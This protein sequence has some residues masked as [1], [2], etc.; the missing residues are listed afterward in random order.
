MI[1]IDAGH[2]GADPGAIGSGIV[3]KNYTLMISQQMFDRFRQLGVPAVMTRTTDE[4][5]SPEARVQRILNAFG[6]R[7]D[8]IVLSNHLNATG[9]DG[10]EVIYALRNTDRLARLI[11]EEIA[12]TNQNVRR[13]YQRRLP[14]DTSKDYYFIHRNTGVTEPVMIEYGFVDSPGNDPEIIKT[15]WR[16]MADAVV[17]AVGIYRGV[18]YDIGIDEGTYV[19]QPGDT[20]WAI[21]RRFN[22]SVDAIRQA[23]NLTTDVLSVGQR[24]II[25]GLT[26][27]PLIDV[28][29]VVQPGDTLFSLARAYDTTVEEIM[30]ANNLTTTTL[31]I[32]QQLKIPTPPPPETPPG[33]TP[34]PPTTYTVRAGDTLFSIA[35]QFGTTVQALRD[36]NNLTTDLLALGQVLQ[37]PIPPAPI[38]PEQPVTPPTTYTVKAGDTLYDIAR[39]FGTTVTAIMQLNNL[40]TTALSIGQVLQ[41][42]SGNPE[43]S[44]N[45]DR[46]V[47][48]SPDDPFALPL[49]VPI[50]VTTSP[51]II[52]YIVKKGDTLW[53]ISRHYGATVNDIKRLN[54]L[55][56]DTITVGQRLL[57]P[58]AQ[59]FDIPPVLA[60]PGTFAYTV[61]RGD[62]L[63][64][65]AN[66]HDTSVSAI[67][68]LN[69][70]ETDL[71]TV[72]QV[73]IV[74][75]TD[76]KLA[77]DDAREPLP[78]Q[79]EITSPIERIESL[80]VIVRYT[81]E[82]GDTLA[83]IAQQFDSTVETIKSINNLTTDVLRVGQELL[84]PRLPV[85]M[86]VTTDPTAAV[87][88]VQRGDTLWSIARRFGTTAS[89]LKEM[90][91]L[92]N[93]LIK[94]GQRLLV[95]IA[96]PYVPPP[97]TKAHI[98]T[99][100]ETLTSIA[101]QYKTTVEKIRELNNITGDL[102]NIGQIILVPE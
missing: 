89:K 36:L 79:I 23:N 93:N 100:G 86:T 40:T 84:I 22:V 70:L 73:L 38:V 37:I 90:N 51:N 44:F 48:E 50:P 10:A 64:S 33:P 24:L 61:E 78:K 2:G 52:R 18:P 42:P 16:D 21:A 26:P 4:T 13:W 74:P 101:A 3:E 62:T 5:L 29:H 82:R 97:G 81:V 77:H 59:I 99:R 66:R 49:G 27:P 69:N 31:S 17:R 80:P 96:P 63:W 28:T 8:V 12:K 83:G 35:R 6:N 20:L 87:Y 30:K 98:V 19:V 95:P 34:P 94:V 46:Q 9:G 72:G 56:N 92:P 11:T 60:P 41:I 47:A 1:V 76:R 39:R 91:E 102:I 32:G 55:T 65:I 15:K 58:T 71:I 54:N 43:R 88:I 25:P 85:G 57:V 53:S 67:R 14:T 7:P 68:V 75:S 45:I